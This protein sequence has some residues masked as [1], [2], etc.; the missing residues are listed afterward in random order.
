MKFDFVIGNPPYQE[1]TENISE[2][3]GQLRRKSIFQYFQIAAD[4]LAK[5]GTALIYPAGRWIQRSGRG[6]RDFGLKQI[7]DKR[8]AAIYYYPDAKDVF[9][10]S[11]IADGVSIVIKRQDK[12]TSGFRYVFCQNGEEHEFAAANPGEDIMPL[13]PRHN[14]IVEKID[15]FSKKYNLPSLHDSIYPQKLFGI[16]SDFVEKNPDKVELMTQDSA[17][18]YNHKVKLFSNDRAGKAGRARW[19]I[20]D[21]NCVATAQDLID[22]WKVVVSSANAGGQKRDNQLAIFD[23][24]SVFGRARI[25]LGIFDTLEEAQ[26]FYL[27]MKTYL[28]RFAFLMTDENLVTLG[29]KVPD[30]LEYKD[31]PLVTFEDSLDQQLFELCDF[32]DAERNYVVEIVDTLR[33]KDRSSKE[34]K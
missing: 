5:S 19:Y 14:I 24:H 31:N 26:N 12:Q 1:E 23:N 9:P 6:M 18:D 7:N 4:D 21:R 25:A 15:A 27:Y 34:M 28:V 32:T 8:L 22:K 10:S 16:E 30:L 13:D 3:N 17:I 33:K 20:A 2:T 11:D 29:I